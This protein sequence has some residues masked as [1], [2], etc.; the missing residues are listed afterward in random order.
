MQ[1]KYSHLSCSVNHKFESGGGEG[2]VWNKR[3]NL[4]FGDFSQ[5]ET[6]LSKELRCRPDAAVDVIWV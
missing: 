5:S 1:V 4:S 2:G 6:H 3:N